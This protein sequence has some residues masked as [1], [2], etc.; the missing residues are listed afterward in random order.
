MK[1]IWQV[2]DADRAA[3]RALPR[4]WGHDAFVRKRALTNLAEVKPDASLPGFSTVARSPVRAPLVPA[5][6]DAQAPST[7]AGSHA[8]AGTLPQA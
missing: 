2:E 3:V 6:R 8:S 5:A 4:E 1:L 7:A